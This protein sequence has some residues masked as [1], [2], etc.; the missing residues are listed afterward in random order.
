MCGIHFPGR[1]FFRGEICGRRNVQ[2]GTVQPNDGG[3]IFRGN[4]HWG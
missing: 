1:G 2:G 3:N 4:F